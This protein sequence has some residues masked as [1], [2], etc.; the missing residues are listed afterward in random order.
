MLKLR[1]L[2]VKK[3]ANY[4]KDLGQTAPLAAKE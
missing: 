4:L 2:E 3:V 1:R